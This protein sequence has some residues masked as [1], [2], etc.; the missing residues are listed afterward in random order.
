[1]SMKNSFKLLF[2]SILLGCA[3]GAQQ[4]GIT[5]Q[6]NTPAGSVVRVDHC[7]QQICMWIVVV[8]KTAPS[9]VD[10]YNPDPA[11]R[12]RSICGLQIGSGFVLRAP[13]E[14][15]D[16]TLYDPKTGKTYHGQIKLNGNRL[17]L[18]GYVGIPLFGETQTWIRPSAPVTACTT[19][20]EE[21]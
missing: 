11:K 19:S 10:I 17:D 13:D 4:L 8:S 1:M 6:W 14:A 16:G 5:G 15:R 12:K 3:A 21:K 9:T 18:R 2:I 20:G 7:G